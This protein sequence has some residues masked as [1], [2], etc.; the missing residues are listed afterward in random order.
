MFLG[1]GKLEFRLMKSNGTTSE[2]TI[3]PA[4]PTDR[5]IEDFEPVIDVLPED[6]DG[7][8]DEVIRG[9]RF[10][11]QYRWFSHQHNQSEM[12]QIVR[13]GN[14]RGND[15]RYI[16]LWPHADQPQIQ[17]RCTVRRCT[18]MPYSGKIGGDVIDL[19]LSG[20]DLLERRPNPLL[21]RVG[22]VFRRRSLNTTARVF[23]S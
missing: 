12:A 18:V 6:V 23:G 21:D 9:Y 22:T 16:A 5:L 10:R 1:S 20:I 3:V 14:W 7:F 13:V 11:A 15:G 19:E 8:A 4:R 17:V 2:A